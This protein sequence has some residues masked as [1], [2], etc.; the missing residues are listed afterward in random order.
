[1]ELGQTIWRRGA[2]ALFLLLVNKSPGATKWSFNVN[3]VYPAGDA[4]VTKARVW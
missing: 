2:A 3:C 1:M 4:D